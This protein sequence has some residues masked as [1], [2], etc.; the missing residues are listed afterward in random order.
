MWADA[1]IPGK[2]QKE[3]DSLELFGNQYSNILAP[4]IHMFPHPVPARSVS[5][6]SNPR[7]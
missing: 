4:G 2:G 3:I 5:A 7:T 6:V 1:S